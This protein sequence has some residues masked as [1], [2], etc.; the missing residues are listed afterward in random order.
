MSFIGSSTSYPVVTPAGGDT[1]PIVQ[2]G[3][4]KQALVSTLGVV[5]GGG[6]MYLGTVQV[7]TAK[8]TFG[9]A[10]AVSKLAI[11][12]ATSGSTILDATA[13]AG[14]G[15]VTLPTTGTLATLAGAET[16]TNKTL[17][18]PVMTA[19]VL[20]TPA[21]G[22]AT[23]L[24]G[25][26][27][28]TGVTGI[29][30]IAN[31]ATG[32]PTGAKFVRDDGVL[33]V[34]A[35]S[36]TVTNT[37]GNLTSN[38]V[39]LGAGTVD[40]KVVAGVTSDGTSRLQLGVAGSSVGGVE[41]R[42]ATSGT[43]SIVPPT[44]ALGTT[45]L[46]GLAA[47]DTL[48]GLAATQTLTN[49]TL[50]SPTLTTP[51]LGTPASGTLTNCTGLPVAGGGTGAATLAAHGVL[52]GNG[53][54]A[55]AVT[56]AGTA[57]QVLTSNGASADPT[58]QAAAGGGST[59]GTHDVPI[60][61]GAMLGRITNG[62]TYGVLGMGAGKPEIP[63]YAFDPTTQQFVTINWDP[64]KSWNNGT[65]TAI[66]KWAHPA[67][68]TNFGVKWGIRGAAFADAGSL[69]V[70]FGTAQEVADTG[71]TTDTL[72]ISAAISAMTIGNSPA[73]H[74][75]I[76]LEVYRLPSDAADTMAVEARLISVTLL[77]TTN[78]DTDA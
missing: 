10:G 23:N 61:A 72:Y 42:N 53:T 37:G 1:V 68:T 8:K 58:F 2:G 63:Y 28:T 76:Q 25:L 65:I 51:A 32:T 55:V 66:F 73:A 21:S 29:L 24:T 49:K 5:S 44:G 30:P 45:V 50:T 38:A 77:I 40:A 62:A 60:P 56:G 4:V 36:G 69:N 15:T 48:V 78:A 17:T 43:M 59:Q 47:S 20:G 14:S 54:S 7:I 19:P 9:A 22:V 70:S 64:P 27:L 26:P 75:N 12:G 33:A 74:S 6:D 3:E 71:G 35:G 39:V 13:V 41:L 18:A 11:A 67:T 31:M 34:P 46:T 52:I 57:G 16:L